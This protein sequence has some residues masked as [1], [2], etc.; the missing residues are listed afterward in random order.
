MCSFKVFN[1]NVCT[2]NVHEMYYKFNPGPT[3]AHMTDFA[4]TQESFYFSR[5]V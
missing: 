1:Q 2:V 3:L 5:E 4:N